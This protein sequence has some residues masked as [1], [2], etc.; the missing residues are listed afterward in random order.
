MDLVK[1][2]QKKERDQL[3][4][5]GFMEKMAQV[6]SNPEFCE[7]FNEYFKDWSDTKASLMMM[8]TYAFVDEQYI[9]QTGQKLSSEEIMI[10]V[11]KMVMNSDYRQLLVNE[12]DNFITNKGRFLEYYQK[13]IENIPEK[14][15]NKIIIE[16]DS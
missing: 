8:K 7:F 11:K 4:Q 12:M 5:F 1:V 3:Q 16:K 2:P 9:N 13:S 10:I 15:V 6:M 14:N